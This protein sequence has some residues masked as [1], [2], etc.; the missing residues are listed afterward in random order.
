MATAT[1]TTSSSSSDPIVFYDIAS[2]PPV[3]PFAPNPWKTRYAL[4]FKRAHFVTQ[5][6]DLA[7]VTA[8][9]KSLGAEPV[10][11]HPN[12][13]PFYTLPAIKDPGAN[14]TVVADSFDIAVYL[15]K[16]YPEAPSLF[17]NAS[18]IGLY[19]SFNAH[20]DTIFPLGAALG[21][22]DFPFNPAT[23]EQCQAEFCRRIG[24]QTWDELV[25]RGGGAEEDAGIVP[26]VARGR[27]QVLP[28]LRGPLYWGQGGRLR[29][30]HH[31]WM[32]DDVQPHG[33]GVGGNAHVAWGDL[34][35]V[36]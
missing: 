28:V 7:D 23:A 30:Y 18:S 35:Q 27:R 29:G 2:G 1:T 22:E 5:W 36:T 6:V 11:F 3:R 17:R 13:E 24:V 15:D 31:W 21:C 12:G 9:R 26:E 16:K 10:R 33:A 32:A 8:T 34:G 19:A 4:N 25:V 14:D 20:M